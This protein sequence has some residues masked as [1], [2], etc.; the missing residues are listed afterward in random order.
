MYSAQSTETWSKYKVVTWRIKS[1]MELFV[2]IFN[3]NVRKSVYMQLQK[4]LHYK[5][6]AKF[7]K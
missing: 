4:L 7:E 5:C 6:V 1:K 2:D 3:R